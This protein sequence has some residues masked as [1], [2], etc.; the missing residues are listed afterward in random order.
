MKAKRDET[1]EPFQMVIRAG[2]GLR[3]RIKDG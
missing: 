1:G 2:E 3:G